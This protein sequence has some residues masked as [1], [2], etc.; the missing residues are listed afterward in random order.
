MRRTLP[1]AVLLCLHA[2]ATSAQVAA[3]ESAGVASASGAP[4]VIDVNAID[5]ETFLAIA[6]RLGEGEAPVIDGRLNDEVWQR[7][8]VMGRFIQREPRFGA[9][10]TERTEFRILYDATTLYFAIWAYDSEPDGIRA[11]ELKRD[12]GLRKGDQVK[13]TIDTFHDHRNAF[14]FSTNPLGALKDAN[15]VDNG[16]AINY[17]WNAVWRC[18]TSRDGQ[19]WYVEIAIPLSQLRFRALPGETTW[20]LNVCR[21]IMRKNEE[22]YWVPFPREWGS[23][24]LARMSHAGVLTGLRDLPAR[25]RLELMPFVSP[26]LARDFEEGSGTTAR[27]EYGGDVRVGVTNE[28]TAELT[29]NTDFAQ[30]EADQEVV[31]LSRFPIS[32]PEKRQFFTESAGI[33]DFGTSGSSL[34]GGDG[35]GGGNSRG[36]IPL[37][38]SRRIGL[39]EGGAVPLVGGG[40]LTGRVGPYAVG[41]MNITTESATIETDDGPI[42]VPRRNYTAFRIKR[43]VLAQSSVGAIVLNQEASGAADNRSLG[44]DG[45]FAL[46]RSTVATGI[47]AK[48]FSPGLSGRDLA[49]AFDI[50]WKTDRFNAGATYLD[51]QERF[52]AEM[53]FIRRSDIRNLA[54]SAGWSP[55]PRW[56]GVRQVQTRA[57]VDY[58]ENHAGR[59]ESRSHRLSLDVNRHD[60]SNLSF[61]FE[62]NYDFLPEDWTLGEGTLGVG[63][64][65]W[66]EYRAGLS[67][68]QSRR[69]YGSGHVGWG[70]Y[71]DGRRQTYRASLNVVPAD[72]LLIETSYTRNRIVRAGVRPYITNT[73]TTRASYSFSPELFVKAFLQ[74]NDD[75]QLATVNLLLWYIYKPGS[76]FY[77]VYDTG[78]DT[79]LPGDRQYRIKSRSLA[80][81]MTYWISR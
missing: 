10:S 39:T 81:K 36:L 63:G 77:L 31:N 6:A 23:I 54:A 47:F 65:L 71:Y 28:L 26:R 62:R 27:A 4:E 44:V 73:L 50:D 3:P 59:L 25:R 32:F 45:A 18:R 13:I 69:V 46:G 20:G 35:G 58:F 16:R 34:L 8:P 67:T 19:G 12:A 52:N 41:L 70:G 33:F 43:P 7:A 9:V 76:D 55:R 48:T 29:I 24:G 68:N 74:Y 57:A 75:R 60:S 66:N 42:D 15:S 5:P 21:I 37:F 80:L 38:Y 51:I 61:D 30:V 22:T 17:D 40:K 53:G 64:Y 14:Y 49:G 2:A 11:S 56:P 72:T 1:L 79:G 78:W